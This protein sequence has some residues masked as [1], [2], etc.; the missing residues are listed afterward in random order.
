MARGVS[1][2]D[3]IPFFV[4]W[5]EAVLL[6]AV[7]GAFFLVLGRLLRSVAKRAGVGAR[8]RRA[9]WETLSLLWL[10]TSAYLLLNLTGI[11]SQLTILTAG[12]IAGLVISMGLQTTLANTF[13]GIFLLRDQAIRVG[14]RIEYAGTKG[15][16]LR[17]ALRN[18][19]IETDDG[20]VA[21]IGNSA[22][23]AGPLVN[24]SARSRLSHLF[25]P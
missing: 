4:P 2:L 25:E 8:A 11:A 1:V 3:R 15:R 18:T 19:W 24:R 12:G 6:V 22:L 14:D 7:S 23:S 16:V 21:V 10:V 17:I 5:G 9:I 20:A 13:A